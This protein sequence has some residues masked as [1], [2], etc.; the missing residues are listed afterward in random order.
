MSF[1]NILN[2]KRRDEIVKEYLDT[3]KRIKD[4]NLQERARDFAHQESLEES[5]KPVVRSAAASTE[6]ITNELIPIKEGI[7]ALNTKLQSSKS[8]PEA[9]EQLESEPEVEEKESIFEEIV[10]DTPLEKLDDYFG[11]LLAEDNRYVMGD[12]TVQLSGN[13]IIVE[14]TH[15]Q[16]TP[17]LW[18]L[19]MFKKPNE[20]HYNDHDLKK[21]EKLV[22]Q[23]NV[24]SA[25][26][27]VRANS[28]IKA[29]YKW[30][31]IFSK[32]DKKGQGIEFLPSDINSLQTK[33]T[34][35]LGEYQAGN[36][37]ATR[38]KIVAISDNLLKRKVISNTEYRRINNLLQ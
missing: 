5:L 16:G 31:N 14:D 34:Y 11:I 21:Y 18:I 22:Q 4:R 12:K 30:R 10:R 17:G 25:P 28:K 35:L 24:I 8:E 15:Y 27:N 13:D 7:T 32:F 37:S 3:K 19:I 33:L 9:V 2:P 20:N 6:A 1:L 29:T 36:T 26:N 23:T 38:N